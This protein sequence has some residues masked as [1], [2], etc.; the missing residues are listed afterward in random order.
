[1]KEGVSGAIKQE[2]EV[3]KVVDMEVE[4]LLE[5]LSRIGL[6]EVFEDGRIVVKTTVF[7]LQ[8]WKR[9]AEELGLEIVNI[10]AVALGNARMRI[11]IWFK[12]SQN[13]SSPFRAGRRSVL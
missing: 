10:V 1:M 13:E 5:H 6:M 11:E 12:K 2:Q 7:S 9:F 3:R 8:E 4:K